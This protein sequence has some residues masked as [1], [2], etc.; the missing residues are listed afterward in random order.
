M[1]REHASHL[2]DEPVHSVPAIHVN[3]VV[4]GDLGRDFSRR[5]GAAGLPKNAEN[6]AAEFAVS[7]MRRALA[8]ELGSDLLR[9]GIGIENADSIV[10]GFK[11]GAKLESPLLGLAQFAIQFGAFRGKRGHDVGFAHAGNFGSERISFNSEAG[12]FATTY[13]KFSPTPDLWLFD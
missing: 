7:E 1:T 2:C 8:P 10:E 12:A 11:V 9:R 5:H 3:P 6:H 13:R 4:A